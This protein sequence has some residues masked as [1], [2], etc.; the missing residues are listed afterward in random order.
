MLQ[1]ILGDI[2]VFQKPCASKMA[3]LR[4]KDTSRSLCYPILCAHCLPSCQAV[5]QA[6]GLLVRYIEICWFEISDLELDLS[7]SLKETNTGLSIYGDLL[8]VNALNLLLSEI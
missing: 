6:P 5:R 1:V 2:Q 8:L 3:G 7:R 4:V